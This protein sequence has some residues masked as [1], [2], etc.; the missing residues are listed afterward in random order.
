MDFDQN[1]DIKH[2]SSQIDANGGGLVDAHFGLA[3]LLAPTAPGDSSSSISSASPPHEWHSQAW[4]DA[5]LMTQASMDPSLFTTHSN[6]GPS[7]F[8]LQQGGLIDIPLFGALPNVNA[9]I[10]MDMYNTGFSFM[11]PPAELHKTPQTMLGTQQTTIPVTSDNGS[12]ADLDNDIVAAVKRITGITNAQVAGAPVSLMDYQDYAMAANFSDNTYSSASS[13]RSSVPPQT[14]EPTQPVTPSDEPSVD[15]NIVSP[16]TTSRPK[17]A[18]T[19][20][21]RRYRTNLNTCIVGLRNAI[22]AVRYLDK[23]Y[24]PPSGNPDVLDEHNCID[25][26][27]AARK[28]SKATIMSKAREYIHVLKKRETRLQSEVTEMK[29]LVASLVDGPRLLQ[30]WERLWALRQEAEAADDEMD[31]ADMESDEEDD[32]SSDERPRKRPKVAAPIPAAVPTKTSKKASRPSAPVVPEGVTIPVEDRPK[33]RGRPPKNSANLKPASSVSPQVHFAPPVSTAANTIAPQ[34]A[35]IQYSF[36]PGLPQQ[37]K[38]P[39]YL[40]A[41]FIFLS[42]FKPTAHSADVFTNEHANHSHLGRVLSQDGFDN[43]VVNNVQERPWHSHPALHWLHTAAMV[44]LLVALAVSIAPQ[45]SRDKVWRYWRSLFETPRVVK[46]KDGN[47]ESEETS[48]V[49]LAEKELKASTSTPRS[50]QKVF[51]ALQAAAPSPS[52]EE[53]CL[54]A[55][56]RVTSKQSQADELWKQASLS[57]DTRDPLSSAFEMKVEEAADLL[58]QPV[59]MKDSRSCIAIIASAVVEKRVEQTLKEVFVDEA[60]AICR[61]STYTTSA[62]RRS[63]LH[64]AS[65]DLMARAT[66]LGGRPALLVERWESINSVGS[67]S[68][69]SELSSENVQGESAGLTLLKVLALMHR[70]FPSSASRSNGL[71]SPPPSPLPQD[72]LVKLERALRISLDAKVFHAYTHGQQVGAGSAECELERERC[73]EVRIARDQLISNLSQAAR[74]RRLLALEGQEQD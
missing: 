39:A 45:S 73:E 38:R 8:D 2:D 33:K 36:V 55:L 72:E 18:H 12:F 37:Q 64:R 49:A 54:Q 23:N 42:F 21:E 5:N 51:S 62:T 7:I 9:N 65:K 31:N 74:V 19:T 41:S 24:Q 43:I 13:D 15:D 66:A 63:A 71:S 6:A 70:I 29:R 4:A 34:Q 35:Q 58:R 3:D 52:T 44:A 40:M 57:I 67:L 60:L 32:E 27:K 30:E 25:G 61:G 56:L 17:T 50:K 1:D 26:V 20:I 11:L 46:E 68:K 14:L 69:A 16:T 48:L 28:I 22:P 59:S 53:L 10:P 47:A